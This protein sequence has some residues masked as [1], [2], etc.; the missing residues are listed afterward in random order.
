V[1]DE[2]LLHRVVNRDLVISQLLRPH[3]WFVPVA[4][5]M[6]IVFF[7]TDGRISFI[8]F[9]STITAV[10]GVLL[11]PVRT[12]L[13]DWG[14][15]VASASD[16]LR[17][18]RG[19]LEMRSQTVPLGRV[20]AV[21]VTWPW[22]WRMKGWVRVR[23]DIAGSAVTVNENELAGTLLPV[24][25]VPAAHHLIAET[26]PGFEL[27]TVTIALAP[28]RAR[29]LSPLAYRVLGYGRT[30]HAF[31][32]QQGLITREL[33]AVSLARIQSVRLRQGPLERRLGLASVY[34]DLAGGRSAAALHRDIAEARALATDLAEQ[35][36]TA[37][38]T[39]SSPT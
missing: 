10:L 38:R 8:G 20:Q 31:V 13:G 30:E 22:L 3:W 21:T 16:G 1:V 36:R 37:R 25:T 35:A 14:F 9:A 28:R 11:A 7:A 5:A 26:L 2:R 4:A 34:V 24:G 32:A 39:G 27:T 29:W 15:T 19:A 18:R 23:M 12:V 17:V 33:T 6:P